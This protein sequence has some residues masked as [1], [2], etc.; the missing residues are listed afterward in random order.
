NDRVADA[1]QVYTAARVGLDAAR[2][3]LSEWT[4]LYVGIASYYRN[5]LDD[6]LANLMPV[7]EA[8]AAHHHLLL[9]G[10][11]LRM[12]GLIHHVSGRIGQGIDDY[13]GALA[14]FDK[15]GAR[16]DVSAIHSS[17]ADILA[18]V[19]DSRNAW[20]HRGRALDGLGELA[21]PRVREVIL[22]SSGRM[23]QR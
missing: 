9:L 12:T 17:L 7:R 19:G 14:A 13:Q 16:Q 8:A 4:G 10:R 2:S 6:S 5:Q 18:Q 11:T 21:S 3:P 20:L 23:A 1:A 22:Q 15:A